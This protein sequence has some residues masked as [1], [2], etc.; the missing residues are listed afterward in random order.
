[1]LCRGRAD[2][3]AQTHTTSA[4][5]LNGICTKEGGN[6]QCCATALCSRGATRRGGERGR[7]AA[8]AQ[9]IPPASII[10]WKGDKVQNCLLSFSHCCV[11]TGVSKHCKVSR[12]PYT[13]YTITA[14][15]GFTW[16][17]REMK[18]IPLKFSAIQS[19]GEQI[20][21]LPL[22]VLS[23]SWHHRW[24]KTQC[25]SFYRYS[26][27][28]VVN[29]LSVYILQSQSKCSRATLCSHSLGRFNG[30]DGE[31]APPPLLC[32]LLTRQ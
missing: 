32:A 12:S 9:R 26:S 5:T 1:M 13:L 23:G 27:A 17:C 28:N 21:A 31:T 19:P 15:H 3:A 18:T 22:V 29:L 7:R 10:Y 6:Q 14:V 20:T 24:L 30:G 16:N 25:D 4:N 11:S 8:A 2:A